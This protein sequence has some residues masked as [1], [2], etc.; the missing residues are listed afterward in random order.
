MFKSP[1]K[2]QH[3]ELFIKNSSEAL[4]DQRI[5]KIAKDLYDKAQHCQV[6]HYTMSMSIYTLFKHFQGQI[7]K[8]LWQSV[9]ILDNSFSEEMLSATQ[10]EFPLVQWRPFSPVLL[11]GSKVSSCSVLMPCT[12]SGMLI[13]LSSS[14]SIAA[15]AL[16]T[17]P[18]SYAN[19]SC[20]VV[21]N[22]TT[23]FG[24]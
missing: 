1:L 16:T 4:D 2:I 10:V 3:W 14:G 19:C 21:L 11:Q 9:P 6:H 12:G 22:S 20:V 15:E 18:Q 24:K 8:L 17:P 7:S 23:G 13:F 5:I